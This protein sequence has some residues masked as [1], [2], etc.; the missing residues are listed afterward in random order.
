MGGKFTHGNRRRRKRN[1]L[2][3]SS[4]LPLN[5]SLSLFPEEKERKTDGGTP[6][7][8]TPPTTSLSPL[9]LAPPLTCHHPTTPHPWCGDWMYYVLCIVCVFYYCCTIGQDWQH[10]LLDILG[11]VGGQ[12][13]GW[14]QTENSAFC[15]SLPTYLFTST[16]RSSLPGKRQATTYTTCPLGMACG[17]ARQ[18][19]L[20]RWVGG[21]V[22]QHSL[23]KAAPSY[24]CCLLPCRAWALQFGFGR[25]YLYQTCPPSPAPLKTPPGNS[26][27]ATHKSLSLLHACPHPP[28][29]M[30]EAGSIL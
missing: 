13:A 9:P 30:R 3:L 23:S 14:G 15:L 10:D 5:I 28:R 11:L 25:T 4:L 22:E 20:S 24:H 29:N 7:T 1:I 18:A 27:Q 8:T 17:P 19:C 12:L 2:I 21:W 16:I 26:K 6:T